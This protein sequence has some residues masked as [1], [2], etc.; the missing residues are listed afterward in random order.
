MLGLNFGRTT[1]MG[2]ELDL[3]YIDKKKKEELDLEYVLFGHFSVFHQE[4]VDFNEGLPPKSIVFLIFLILLFYC[5][6]I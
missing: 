5:F 6:L 2:L 3:E 1:P 4:T